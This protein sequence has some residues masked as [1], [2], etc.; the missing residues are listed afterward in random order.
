MKIKLQEPNQL[1]IHIETPQ[2]PWPLES[3][4]LNQGIPYMSNQ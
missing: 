4:S 3:E 1:R 2:I